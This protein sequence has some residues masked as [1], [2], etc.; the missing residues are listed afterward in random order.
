MFV[1]EMRKTPDMKR[2]TKLS[3]EEFLAQNLLAMCNLVETK[4]NS[5]FNLINHRVS[6]LASSQSFLVL[7]LVT[8]VP[9]FLDNRN[10]L[11]GFI[12]LFIPLIGMV[13][14]LQVFLAVNAAIHVLTLHL[15]P[16][17]GMLTDQLNK[18]AGTNLALLGKDRI[19]DFFGTIP[20]KWIPLTL[21]VTWL[22]FL[23]IVVKLVVFP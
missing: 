9:S 1:K 8:L 6:W 13:I 5:E 23:G 4:I 3:P 17:R 22:F 14:C 7:A 20:S 15:L 18:C 10:T 19:T 21:L 11:I 12:L 2:S 16:E